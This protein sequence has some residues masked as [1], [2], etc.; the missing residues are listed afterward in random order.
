MVYQ[1]A[2]MTMQIMGGMPQQQAPPATHTK[3][4]DG[5]MNNILKIVIITGYN[6]S[7][8]TNQFQCI[9]AL[10]HLKKDVNIHGE[11]MFTTMEA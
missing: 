2:T 8:Q 3:K 5:K 7:I 1:M 10:F 4:A 6:G 9:W 11:S